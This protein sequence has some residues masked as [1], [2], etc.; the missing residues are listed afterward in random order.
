MT[1][2]LLGKLYTWA[3]SIYF[4][5]AGLGALANVDAKLSR[6]GLNATDGD[7][8]VAFILIYCSLMIG[9][10]LSMLAVYLVS[11]RWVYSSIIA[12]VVVTSFIV[13]R[14]IGSY[15]LGSLSN[16][17]ISYILVEAA[18]VSVGVFLLLRSEVLRS[19]C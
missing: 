1:I 9:I 3:L 10:G 18:E 8:R 2:D 15:M 14:L 4:L 13:F 5:I 11:K 12:V 16:T 6:L 19:D 17:Q 7:A